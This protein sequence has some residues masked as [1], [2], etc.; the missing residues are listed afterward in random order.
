DEHRLH[1]FLGRG[2]GEEVR[3]PADAVRRVPCKRLTD[4]ELAPEP[5]R[6]Q[7][8]VALHP[9]SS[10]GGRGTLTLCRP[11]PK[12]SRGPT[13]PGAPRPPRSA[14]RSP[15][16]HRAVPASGSPPPCALAPRRARGA[17]RGSRRG[18]RL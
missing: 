4:P 8:F 18:G 16:P 17:L 1:V 14:P 15:T 2:D 12:C 6:E 11:P 5:R 3:R 13:R 7:R 9:A 10:Y